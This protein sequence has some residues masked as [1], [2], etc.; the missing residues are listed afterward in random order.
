[1]PHP[2]ET[3]ERPRRSQSRRRRERK[4][5]QSISSS[6]IVVYN[7]PAQAQDREVSSPIIN[8][9]PKRGRGLKIRSGDVRVTYKVL[10]IV[11]GT[12]SFGTVRSCIH[13]ES[14]T[15]LAIKSIAMKGKAANA[16]LLKNEIA[17]LQ[18]VNH[19]N[20]VRVVD[21]VQDREYIH[22]VMEQCKGGDLFDM[23]VDGK[24]RLGE[25][26]IR[27]I[28]TSLLDAIVAPEKFSND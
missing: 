15:K 12:G 16:A 25:G 10:P 14:R 7:S 19:R 20:V 17:L 1:M 4:P 8:K 6:Q 11:I 2:R 9:P 21:V 5:E 18:Q 28:V 26:K 13:R 3:N 24:V 23:T 22:I 27:T